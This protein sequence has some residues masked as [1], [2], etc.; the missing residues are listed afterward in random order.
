MRSR[1][2][3]GATGCIH[4]PTLSAAVFIVVKRRRIFLGRLRAGRC[5]R[6]SHAQSIH[7]N[8]CT[9]PLDCR[10][11]PMHHRRAGNTPLSCSPRGGEQQNLVLSLPLSLVGKTPSPF[12]TIPTSLCNCPTATH[13]SWQS[14]HFHLLPTRRLHCNTNV[15]RRRMQDTDPSFLT[16]QTEPMR[17]RFIYRKQAAAAAAAAM[18]LDAGAG[19]RRE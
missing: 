18:W 19:R 15:G 14:R 1:L 6:H 11:P 17:A 8:K 3:C 5:G 13:G 10:Y 16:P 12:S 4:L 2:A 9:S 7:L